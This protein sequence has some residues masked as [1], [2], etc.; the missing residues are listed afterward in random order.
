[1][2]GN[3]SENLIEFNPNQGRRLAGGDDTYGNA[4]DDLEISSSVVSAFNLTGMMAGME[5]QVS[6]LNPYAKTAAR[7][8]QVNNILFV[9]P[10]GLSG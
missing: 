1:M 5:E 8:A 4:E 9:L 7:L 2:K 3:Q 6:S 10:N